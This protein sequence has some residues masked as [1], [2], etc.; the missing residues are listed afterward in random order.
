MQVANLDQP[1]FLLLDQGGLLRAV[2]NLFLFRLG[3]HPFC[4][5]VRQRAHAHCRADGLRERL[6]PDRLGI[7]RPAPLPATV[8][9]VFFFELDGVLAPTLPAMRRCA[10]GK[11]AVL[12]VA[13]PASLAAYRLN[14]LEQFARNQRRVLAL[15]HLAVEAENPRVENM[16][17]RPEDFA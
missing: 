6:A 17:Q 1:R 4:P 10:E 2:G 9:L 3:Q 11:A 8:I 5:R 13:A 15:V 14:P 12:G 16:V 7:A